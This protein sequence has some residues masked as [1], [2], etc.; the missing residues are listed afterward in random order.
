MRG[1]L[2]ELPRWRTPKVCGKQPVLPKAYLPGWRGGVHHASIQFS[3]LASVLV[4]EPVKPLTTQPRVGWKSI[5]STGRAR[6]IASADPTVRVIFVARHTCGQ[7]DSTLRGESGE[8]FTDE[9]SAVD[10]WGIFEYLLETEPA[11]RRGLTMD[12]FRGTGVEERLALRWLLFNEKAI[13]ELE[14]LQ[15]RSDASVVRYE[16]LCAAPLTTARSLLD[17]AS[18]DWDEAVERFL[19]ESTGS[20]NRRYH[21]RLSRFHEGSYA[22]AAASW[23]GA[24]RSHTGG[25]ERKHA[26]RPVYGTRTRRSERWTCRMFHR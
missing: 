12:S 5:E 3:R 10:S 7:I 21:K 11:R 4:L 8:R 25:G 13:E 1:F 2:D 14:E 6:L 17:F 22:L 24:R 9:G 26:R 19:W 23:S 18:L 16:D 20:D 15:G